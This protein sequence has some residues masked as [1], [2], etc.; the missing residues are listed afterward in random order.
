[1]FLSFKERVD[2]ILFDR[3]AASK[4]HVEIC[5]IPYYLNYYLP[6]SHNPVIEGQVSMPTQ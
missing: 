5:D 3:M 1:M 2:R 6:V 4:G